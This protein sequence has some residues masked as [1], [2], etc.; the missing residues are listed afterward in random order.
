[1]ADAMGTRYDDFIRTTE[2]RHKQSCAALW[3][4]LQAAGDI[5]L[6][7]YEGWYAVRDEAYYDEDE[8]TVAAG[9]ESRSRRRGAPVEWVREPSLF[10]PPVGLAGPAA[11]VLR[12]APRFIGAGEPPQRGDRASCAAGC[13]DL[14]VSRTSFTLGHSGARRRRGT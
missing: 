11:G 9:R 6:G 5:Y 4:R 7:G 1:M 12:R 2:P 13:N 3:L 10:L 8:L 14:S